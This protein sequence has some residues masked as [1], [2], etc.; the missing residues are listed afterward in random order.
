MISFEFIDSTV[1][2]SFDHPEISTRVHPAHVD[3]A[4]RGFIQNL[5]KIPD[6]IQTLN[7]SSG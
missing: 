5:Q 1:A 4:T 6:P 2:V 3:Q 7:R